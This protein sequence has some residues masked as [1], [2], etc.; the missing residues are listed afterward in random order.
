MTRLRE[1]FQSEIRPKLMSEMNYA[2][3]MQIP[4]VEK[5][6]LNMGVGEASQDRKK[7]DGAVEEMALIAG[8][9]PVITVARKSIATFKL[10]NGILMG[11]DTNSIFIGVSDNALDGYNNNIVNESQINCQLDYLDDFEPPK[12]TFTNNN[13]YIRYF[14]PHTDINEWDE[15]GSKIDLD[16][17]YLFDS[18]IRSTDYSSLFPNNNGM[19][20]FTVIEPNLTDTIIVDENGNFNKHQTFIDS[21]KFEVIHL[22]GIQ[23]SEIKFILDRDKGEKTGGIEIVDPE[24][25]IEVNTDK[26][27]N[28]TINLLNICVGQD[29]DTFCPDF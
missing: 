12:P 27:I 20:W 14:I 26:E 2:N 5:I 11:S 19:D 7:I 24:S 17:E 6:V 28:I 8:Q 29:I 16:V 25:G 15:W 4:R 10:Q 22:E 1:Y 13:N 18:D 3:G 21:I 9:K 23:C